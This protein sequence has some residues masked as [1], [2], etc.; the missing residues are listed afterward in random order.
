[1]V[2]HV[3]QL[4]LSIPTIILIASSVQI[5]L[6]LLRY[7]STSKNEECSSLSF[8]SVMVLIPCCNEPVEVLRRSVESCQAIDYPNFKVCVVENSTDLK[9]KFLACSYLKEK[10][11]ILLSIAN[12]GSKA[13][14]I[15]YA[16]NYVYMDYIV[17]LDSDQK[18]NRQILK[19]LVA[20]IE[21]VGSEVVCVQTPQKYEELKL[22]SFWQSAA[23]IYNEIFY[24]YI[25]GLYNDMGFMPCLGTNYIIRT[26]YI[27]T[28]NGWPDI[29]L[30][31]DLA[32]S[33][34]TYSRK[35]KIKYLNETCSVGIAPSNAKS[36][37]TQQV[38][39]AKGTAQC[40]RYVLKL[41]K[42]VKM[43]ALVTSFFTY[44]CIGI[45]VIFI[46]CIREFTGLWLMQLQLI[47]SLISLFG[48]IWLILL[49]EDPRRL[50]LFIPMTFIHGFIHT[51]AIWLAITRPRG[52]FFVTR[53]HV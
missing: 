15:N 18:V 5:I 37:F 40:V 6:A 43:L 27:K 26:K 29:S 16:L 1:M 48:V 52:K 45:S 33:L 53:K 19:S 12:M 47:S 36:Y 34:L 44:Y 22:A 24:K 35:Y 14:A 46:S 4:L 3:T 49:K 17:V 38:R 13:A 32:L 20:F 51:Y 2:H 42:T 41:H 21:A 9:M 31:E 8:P 23:C 10:C 7:R 50:L 11:D 30:T 39:W 28:I 25:C